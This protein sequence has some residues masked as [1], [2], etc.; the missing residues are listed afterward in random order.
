MKTSRKTADKRPAAKDAVNAARGKRYSA[1][2]KGAI[3]AMVH[4]VNA[5]RGRGGITAASQKFNVSPLTI[6]HW[7]RDAAV[8]S[9]RSSWQFNGN[10]AEIFRELADLHEQITS[11]QEELAKLESRFTQLKSRL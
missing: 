4:E 3:I 6:S 7:M 2:E 11:K 9:P 8:D 1:K 5:Q 10:H